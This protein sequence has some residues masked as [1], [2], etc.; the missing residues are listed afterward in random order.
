MAFGDAPT[1]GAIAIDEG[2]SVNG[3]GKSAMPR[4]P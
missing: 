3:D 2:K 4:K 1:Q